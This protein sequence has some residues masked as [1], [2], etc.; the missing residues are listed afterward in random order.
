MLYIIDFD[1]AGFMPH[2]FMSFLLHMPQVAQDFVRLIEHDI[3]NLE[4]MQ[5][6]SYYFCSSASRVGKSY[7]GGVSV[8]L[9]IPGHS[10]V[11]PHSSISF[12]LFDN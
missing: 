7:P 10:Q 1:E 12:A 3:G 8:W 2:S 11:S 9:G 4:I 6:A 5:T